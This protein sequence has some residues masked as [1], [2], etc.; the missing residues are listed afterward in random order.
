MNGITNT[1]LGRARN[2][3]LERSKIPGTSPYENVEMI[4][5]DKN[6]QPKWLRRLCVNV[7]VH[8]E[9]KAE[10]KVEGWAGGGVG[11][12]EIRMEG[13]GHGD[14]LVTIFSGQQSDYG[15]MDSEFRS[16]FW[17]HLPY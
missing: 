2:Q 8:G 11:G 4:R 15:S 5:E 13:A 16:H 7:C 17:D 12:M 14:V 10:W 3:M 6:G 9:V 1:F